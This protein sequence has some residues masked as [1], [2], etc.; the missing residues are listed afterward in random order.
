MSTGKL[1][2]KIKTS[3]KVNNTINNT[4][5]NNNTNN[6]NTLIMMTVINE[7]PDVQIELKSR[8]VEE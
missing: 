5:A 3:Q 6:T 4:N 7:V 8:I 2:T 1:D